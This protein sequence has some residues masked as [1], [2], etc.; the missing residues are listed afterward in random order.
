MEIIKT[1]IFKNSVIRNTLKKTRERR[2]S[3]I[4][5]QYEIKIDKSHLSES[6]TKHLEGLFLEAKWFYNSVIASESFFDLSK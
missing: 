1:N 2:K 4:C 5:K 6:T 3:Q